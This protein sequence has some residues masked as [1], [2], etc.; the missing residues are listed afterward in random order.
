MFYG[1]K[2]NELDFTEY[3]Q[4]MFDLFGEAAKEELALELE[5][6]NLGSQRYLRRLENSIERGVTCPQD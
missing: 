2:Y 5:A 3:Y 4:G 1:K 6:F